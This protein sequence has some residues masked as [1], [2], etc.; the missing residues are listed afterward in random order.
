MRARTLVVALCAS[1]VMLTGSAVADARLSKAEKVSARTLEQLGSLRLQRLSQGR[2]GLRFLIAYPRIG[3]SPG[4][5]FVRV[6]VV[7]HGRETFWHQQRV[8]TSWAHPVSVSVLLPKRAVVRH[9]SQISIGVFHTRPLGGGVYSTVVVARR[10][11]RARAPLRRRRQVPAFTA[12]DYL[13]NYTLKNNTGQTLQLTAAPV[14]CV[15]DQGQGGSDP[16]YV[17]GFNN[18]Q[19]AP[20]STIT[21]SIQADSNVSHSPAGQY[22]PNLPPNNFPGWASFAI[23]PDYANALYDPDVR[24]FMFTAINKYTSTVASPQLFAYQQQAAIPGQLTPSCQNTRSDFALGADQLEPVTGTSG[25]VE[26]WRAHTEVLM[27]ITGGND[28]VIAAPLFPADDYPSGNPPATPVP[29]YPNGEPWIAMTASGNEIDVNPETQSS[30]PDPLGFGLTTCGS[31]P[32]WMQCQYP[33]G[34]AKANTPLFNVAFPGSHDSVTGSL[35]SNGDWIL[36]TGNGDPCSSYQSAFNISP[37]DVYNLGATQ[38]YSILDQLDMGIR[39]FDMRSAY[40]NYYPGGDTSKSVVQSS[41]WSAENPTWRPLHTMFAMS[42]VSTEA[43]TIA[44]WAAAH[45]DE[46]VIADYNHVCQEAAP[47][48]SGFISQLQS[49]AQPPPTGNES[50]KQPGK[51]VSL[52]DVAY[53][54]PAG[55][56]PEQLPATTIQQVRN[57]GRNVIVLLDPG[58]S[59]QQP[60]YSSSSLAG[61]GFHPLWDSTAPNLGEGKGGGNGAGSPGNVPINHLFPNENGPTQTEGCPIDQFDQWGPAQNIQGYPVSANSP[62]LGSAPILQNYRGGEPDGNGGYPVPFTQAQTQYSV[63]NAGSVTDETLRSCDGLLG[64]E[65]TYLGRYQDQIFIGKYGASYADVPIRNSVVNGTGITPN[66]LGAAL[67]GGTGQ[68]WVSG[69]NWAPYLNITIADAIDPGYINTVASLNGSNQRPCQS[70]QGGA[71]SFPPP[72]GAPSNAPINRFAPCG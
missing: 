17:D 53:V 23:D 54:L 65:G 15:Y 40:T 63:T 26:P 14:S 68:P 52:C 4:R 8:A 66:N 37:G 48:T 35:H 19:V 9:L 18:V 13:K 41:G 45:P 11:D 1:V 59:S 55:T 49:T 25:G 51:S 72:P 27:N 57:S 47:N 10:A 69:V 7:L 38:N 28:A 29:G 43:Q 6:M 3:R 71:I 64:F 36:K 70:E 30:P 60:Y 31:G 33:P 32:D 67:Q 16:S 12:G 46:I 44:T 62:N 58:S 42:T 2:E 20:N 34:S 22:T 24:A 39:Y 5:A 50:D 21:T 61:C 56:S